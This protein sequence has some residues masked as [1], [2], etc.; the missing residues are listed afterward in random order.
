MLGNSFKQLEVFYAI[1]KCMVAHSRRR[2]EQVLAY[3]SVIHGLCSDMSVEKEVVE[4]RL[5]DFTSMLALRGKRSRSSRLYFWH[6]LLS[7]GD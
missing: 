5:V 4:E 3:G 1:A 6:R 7:H 2:S